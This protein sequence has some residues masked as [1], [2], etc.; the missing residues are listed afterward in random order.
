M[1]CSFEHRQSLLR[2]AKIF[3][4]VKPVLSALHADPNASSGLMQ[5][6]VPPEELARQAQI[7]QETAPSQTDTAPSEELGAVRS[8]EAGTED[9]QGS[10][11][12]VKVAEDD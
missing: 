1:L 7:S 3:L 8:R 6:A 9:Q 5:Q 2:L 4:L 10:P 11:K 12:R